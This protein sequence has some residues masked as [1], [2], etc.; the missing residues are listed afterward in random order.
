VSYL[1]VPEKKLST[2]CNRGTSGIDG[3]TSTAVGAALMSNEI[4][5]LITG[6]LAFFYD[7]NAFWNK[8]VPNNLRIVLLNN[9]GG[10]IFNLIDGPNSQPELKNFFLTP[11]HQTAKNMSED[12]GLDYY[13][14]K[15]QLELEELLKTFFDPSERPKIVEISSTIDENSKI[16]R[17]FK[18][19]RI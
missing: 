11:H 2:L 5:T 17:E 1:G 18:S 3:C 8:Y 16:F 4:V 12:F 7:R 19:A 10:G 13:F 15:N 9:K 6:D 14:C